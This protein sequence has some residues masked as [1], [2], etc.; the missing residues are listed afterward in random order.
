[1]TYL[2]AL[3]LALAA[4]LVLLAQN[5]S[6]ALNGREIVISP[7]HG[8]YWHSTL[9][10][11]TQRGLIDGLIEDIHT[12][13]IVHDH[14]LPYLEDSGAHVT[15]CRARTRTLEEH[16]IQNDLGAPIYQETGFW[17]SSS[18]SGFGGTG[19]RFATTSPSGGSTASFRTTITTTGYYPVYVAYRASTNRTSEARVEVTHA[20]GTSFRTV[21]QKRFDLRWVYVGTYPFRAFELAIVTLSSASTSPGVIIADAVKIGDG[22]GSIV[23][24]G[25][26]SGQLRWKEC[27]RYHAE[28][29]GAPSTVWNPVAGGQDN[30]D[31]VTCRPKFGEWYF[32]GQADLYL[33][34]HT[35]AGGGSGTSTYI[36]NTSPTPGSSAWSS[37]IHNRLITDLRAFWSP[38]WQDRGQLS[39]N[40][41]EVRELVT[42]PGCL[43]EL[44]F[45]DDIGGD[46]E[47]IHHPTF[48][49]ISGRA[50]A[51]AAFEYLAPGAPLP[52]DPPSALAAR[53]NG[54]GGILVSWT[55]VAGATGYR[56]R[57]STDG[58]F[59]FDNGVTVG[60]TTH[61][62]SGVPPQALRF[63]RVAAM[64]SSGVGPD[65]EP[66]GA[67]AAPGSI[68]PLLLVNGF[69]RHDRS[70]KE[71]DNPHHWLTV[72]GAAVAA[73]AAAGYPFD[74]CTNE[75]VTGLLV[76]L[77][78]YRCVGWILGEEST[79]HE[80]FSTVEQSRVASYLLTGG[81]LFFSGAEVGWDLDFQGSA[82][83]RAFYE[84]TLGSDY[85]ADD[86]GVYAT[87]A[88]ST[89]PLSPLPSMGFDNGSAG[90]YNVDFPDVV[91]PKA[92]TGGQVVLRYTTGLGAAVLHGNGRVLGLGFP[93]EAV[94]NPAHRALLMERILALLCPMP[95]RL[96]SPA[97]LGVT[98]PG[99]VDFPNAGNAVYALGASFLPEPGLPL[100]DG[101][102][103]PA[104]ADALL[105]FSTSPAQSVFTGMTGVLD[106]L[107]QG[108]FQVTV[109]NDPGLH[110]FTFTLTGITINTSAQITNIAP[111]VRVTIP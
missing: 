72:D 20:A 103:I 69:D 85:V 88:E 46:I 83:D 43:V 53:N 58:G 17:T 5:P 12:H 105:T 90:I 78:N 59:A 4:P 65:S 41:G 13:E 21:D 44:A 68:A 28:T 102:T 27:S 61:L 38:S 33:S 15:L 96:G 42:M 70:V 75:A 54:M 95:V 16:I 34:L 9:G 77:S 97:V 92:G 80:T 22:F 3:G 106:P 45:H 14:L 87:L 86:A 40:F 99:Q 1:M 101:R 82:T 19:Y 81:R 98:V 2:R 76:L 84:S 64:T 74:G 63:F 8:Y 62:V 29:T 39:A 93:L 36:H 71:A 7:G 94:I 11:T 25:G 79:V 57:M 23:R 73:V 56:V 67:R 50:M 110:G 91:Q 107:G 48:R 60:T 26:V 6:G 104:A 10:W 51:K 111:F 35:N 18:S 31:D 37:I 100:G 66:V 32:G 89:G 24:G 55:P 52:L 30:D 47:A 109:P 108:T 49:R